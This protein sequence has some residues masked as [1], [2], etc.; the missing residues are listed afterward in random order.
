M[1]DRN[2]SRICRICARCSALWMRYIYLVKMSA[3]QRFYFL[4]DLYQ[5][6]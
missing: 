4:K 1:M 3:K 2:A 5:V 6:E